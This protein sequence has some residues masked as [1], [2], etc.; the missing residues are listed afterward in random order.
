M[1]WPAAVLISLFV[2]GLFVGGCLP[3]GRSLEDY[4]AEQR[5]G[6]S[7]TDP[8][9]ALPMDAT[10][11]A[12]QGTADAFDVPIEVCSAEGGDPLMVRFDNGYPDRTLVLS[13]I[14]FGCRER[15]LRDIGPMDF[16]IETSFVGH[17]F[18][19]RD[20]ATGALIL[21]W[22]GAQVAGSYRVGVP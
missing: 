13:W 4:A 16:W 22:P 1:R 5:S 2:G 20:K 7:G 12:P 10:P 18:R 17:P 19:L 3:D 11:D 21:H 14:D 6:D 15:P 8:D 9:A